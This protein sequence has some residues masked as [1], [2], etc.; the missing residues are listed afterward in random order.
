MIRS[1]AF[2]DIDNTIYQGFS[3]FELLE[4]QIVEN[5]I[6]EQVLTDARAIMQRYKAKAQ[7]YEATI[8]ELLDVYAAG[9]KGVAY[10][11][12]LQSAKEFYATSTKFFEYA[13][14]TIDI[15]RES[16][17]LALVTGEPQFVAEAVREQFGMQL[18]YATEYEVQDGVFTGAVANYLASRHEKHAAIKHLMLGHGAKNSFAFGDSDGDI[19]MLRVVEYPICLNVT[20]RLRS[21]AEKEGW[22]LPMAN[23][24]VT[25][26]K[27]LNAIEMT[28]TTVSHDSETLAE[29]QQVFV[30][31]AFIHHNFDG[32]EKVF[33][34]KRAATKKFLPGVFELPGGHI[35]FGEDLV[36]GLKR[37]IREELHKEIAVGDP[38]AAFTYMNG[39]KGSHSVEII[40]FV[41]FTDI[42]AITL[43]PG[44]HS[45]YKWFAEDELGE[46][47]DNDEK[48]AI[49][50]GFALL[51]GK[52]LHF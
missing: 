49:N 25:L 40:Y 6:A 39:I 33:M 38:F 32:V 7:D 20:D 9:L 10:D 22:H 28:H 17:D 19:E 26:V 37:E 4:K 34:P 46:L 12:V 13:K 45:E 36:I 41:Q 42:E 24:V 52:A 23:E 27:S 21:V 2:F 14:P 15:L 8:I 5:L 51:E 47:P 35:E 18:Y 11:T 16:H 48:A 50:R 1:I 43:N 44:D 31:C 30:A 3:Y 29:G